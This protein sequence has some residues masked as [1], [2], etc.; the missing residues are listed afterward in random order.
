MSLKEAVLEIATEMENEA[1]AL[2][3]TAGA[4]YARMTLRGFAKQ[5]RVACKAAPDQGPAPSVPAAPALGLGAGLVPEELQHFLG[6]QKARE[7]LRRAKNA[8]DAQ[9]IVEQRSVWIVGGP[10]DGACT[11]IPPQMPVGYRIERFGLVY[12]LRQDGNLHPVHTGDES[13]PRVLT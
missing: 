2:E 11:Q 1:K 10:H 6:V 8:T 5:L 4:E 13:P 12:E 3:G 7:D 9:E